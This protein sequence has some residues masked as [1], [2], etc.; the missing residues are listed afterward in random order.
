MLSNHPTI[1][2]PQ[3]LLARARAELGRCLAAGEPCQAE[4]IFSEYPALASDPALALDLIVCEFQLRRSRGERLDPSE[5]YERFPQWRHSLERCLTPLVSDSQHSTVDASVTREPPTEAEPP[6]VHLDHLALLRELGHGGMGIVYEA[7]DPDLGR[8]VALKMIRDRCPERTAVERFRREARILARLHHPNIVEIFAIGQYNGQPCYTMPLLAGSLCQLLAPGPLEPSKAG[9]LMEKVARAIHAA[10]EAGVIHRDLKPGNILLDEHG[11]PQVADFGLAKLL[12]ANATL[13]AGALGTPAYMAPEQT[14]GQRASVA[15]DIWSLGVI[16]YELLAGRRPFDNRGLELPLRSV[17]A[18]PAALPAL[19]PQ[20]SKELET[21][22][23]KCLETDPA[24]RYSSAGELA[25]DLG[26]WLHGEPVLARRPSWYRRATN[27]LR[28]RRQRLTILVLV[29]LLLTAPVAAWFMAP[30]PWAASPP[31]K[32]NAAEEQRQ[33]ALADINHDLDNGALATLLDPNGRERWYRWATE[34][35]R[36][37]LVPPLPGYRTLKSDELCQCELLPDPR[38]ISYRFSVQV[39]RPPQTPFARAGLYFLAEEPAMPDGRLY[40][41]LS[42]ELARQGEDAVLHFNLEHY[43]DPTP[44]SGGRPIQRR[45]YFKNLPLKSLDEW[46]TL[47][48]QVSADSVTLYYDEAPLTSFSAQQLD[49]K[50]AALEKGQTPVALPPL[51]RRGSLGLLIAD[52]T[53]DFRL[54]TVQ[55]ISPP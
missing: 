45:L 54:G 11:E 53:A 24:Q 25:D 40:R 43:R 6:Q 10:H 38:G 34:K 31:P 9:A 32:T 27:Y 7:D 1:E 20:V 19:P 26:R 44:T 41:Y 17:S 3:D 12:D 49:Q 47:A 30:A 22:V 15:S 5:W 4:V 18:P 21:V 29:L 8:R 14:A 36:S 37:P 23:F 42:F 2:S 51:N 16:L 33:K 39:Q 35:D 50:V 48:V 46:H 28:R 13:S 52:G 55:P